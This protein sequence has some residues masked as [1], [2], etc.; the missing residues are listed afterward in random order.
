MSI[1]VAYGREVDQMGLVDLT[2]MRFLYK[3]KRRPAQKTTA[4]KK[5]QISMH[6][7]ESV[8]GPFLVIF[9]SDILLCV[10]LYLGNH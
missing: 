10:I 3:M 9:N 7:H 8:N 6:N 4:P 2:L 5:K 1:V